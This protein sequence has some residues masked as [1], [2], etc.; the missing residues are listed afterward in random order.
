MCSTRTFPKI[1]AFLIV[2][3]FCL[4]QIVRAQAPNCQATINIAVQPQTLCR[5]N[6]PTIVATVANA[7]RNPT[8]RWK[9]NGTPVGNNSATFTGALTIGDAVVCELF[10]DGCSINTVVVSNA[11]RLEAVNLIEPEVTIEANA[12]NI[13]AGQRVTLTATNRS[14]NTNVVY[15][16]MLNGNPVPGS[17]GPEFNTDPATESFE[18]Q[19]LMTVPQCTSPSGG[20]T[21]DLSNTISI[22]VGRV[23]QPTLTI[24]TNAQQVCKGAAVAFT[25]KATGAGADP[26]YLW[27]VNGVIMQ[28]GGA[29]FTTT[30]LNDGDKVQC[31]LEAG[32]PGSC[33]QATP[34]VSNELAMQVTVAQTPTIAITASQTDICFGTAVQMN[35]I[36]TNAGSNPQYQWL[37]N[38]QPIAASGPQ[39]TTTDF[40]DGDVVQCMLT[41]A[42]GCSN[43]PVASNS[44]AMQV[45][46]PPTITVPE[47]TIVI[48]AGEQAQL[49]V[50][51][52]GVPHV[53][54][55]SPQASLIFD[56]T[57]EPLTQPLETSIAFRL[58]ATGTNGCT[59]S[60][61]IWVLVRSKL[62]LPNAFT[63][64]GDGINDVFRIPLGVDLNLESLSVFDRWGNAVFF[65]RN[66][67]AGWDGTFHNKPVPTGMYVFLLQGKYEGA[68]VQL[69]GTVMLT[70]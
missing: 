70:R 14:G 58:Q 55:W 27:Q 54:Q 39:V 15:L 63:P 22:N 53:Y 32:V 4:L 69:K 57:L 49:K 18:V 35:A 24:T 47:D 20:S 8:Y 16:W 68:P 12:T 36:T 9:K 23:Q 61:K 6:T 10:P 65:T 52:T 64:N 38:G 34:V 3:V 17:N 40:N 7:G 28:T 50:A 21:K 41:A 11:F 44:V 2:F 37:V 67:T 31:Q 25:A 45:R 46:Y 62:L 60:S 42:N 66:A 1:A 29:S 51:I 5:P 59:A 56:Q 43:T 33:G 30:S 48:K 19:C 13:C 26:K